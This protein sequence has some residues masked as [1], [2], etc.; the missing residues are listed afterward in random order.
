[1]HG[2]HDWNVVM[3]NFFPSYD[4]REHEAAARLAFESS[5]MSSVKGWRS[6][7]LLIHGDDDR[8]VPFSETVTLAEELRKQGVEFEQ[9]IFPDEVHGF[10][11]HRSW[12]RALQATADFLDKHLRKQ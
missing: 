2:V 4:P 5:P 7:V 9:M 8:N 6:P 12:L 11:L 10:L 1:I 3:R